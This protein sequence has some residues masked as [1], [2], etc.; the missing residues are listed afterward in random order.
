MITFNVNYNIIIIIMKPI[1]NY[2]VKHKVGRDFGCSEF[3]K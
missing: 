3:L 1:F 2:F